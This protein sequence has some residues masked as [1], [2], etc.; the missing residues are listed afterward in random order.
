MLGRENNKYVYY[1]QYNCVRVYL[2]ENDSFFDKKLHSIEVAKH[3]V[4]GDKEEYTSSVHDAFCVLSCDI[5]VDQSLDQAKHDH[6][7]YL[8]HEYKSL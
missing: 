3:L 6:H 1:L 2:H 8:K 4:H 5:T 7:C